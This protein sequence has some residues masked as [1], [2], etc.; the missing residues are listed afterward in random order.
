MSDPDQPPAADLPYVGL[1]CPGCGYELTGA[2]EPR[3]PECGRAFD[4]VGLSRGPAWWQRRP[5]WW[6]TLLAVLLAVYLP[7]TW[8]FWIDYPWSGGYRMHWV[9]MFP[10]LPSLLVLAWGMQMLGVGNNID[11]LAGYLIAGVFIAFTLTAGWWIGRRS[12]VWLV[13]VCVVLFV[14]QVFNALV[15][16]ALFRA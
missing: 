6:V 16:Y 3:C 13:V 8:I 1:R 2:S 4:P 12:W 11:G 15:S 7:N 9:M 14:W 5:S 10:I